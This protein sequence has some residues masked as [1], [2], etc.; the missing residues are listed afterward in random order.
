[1]ISYKTHPFLLLRKM[2]KS[3]AILLIVL[4]LTAQSTFSQ[5]ADKDKITL[6]FESSVYYGSQKNDLSVHL[7][8][9][10]TGKADFSA[11]KSA[12]WEDI[13]SLFDYA[14]SKA[15]IPS[16]IKDISKYIQKG[17]P[18]FI[19]FKYMGDASA[20]STQR[21]WIIRNL[22]A[23]RAGTNL[24]TS[25]LIFVNNPENDEN[26]GWEMFGK[27]FRYR[28]R[29]TKKASESW[30]IVEVFPDKKTAEAKKANISGKTTGA[31]T[32]KAA[33]NQVSQDEIRTAM[34]NL[35]LGKGPDFTKYA[36][37][38]M[39]VI[40]KFKEVGYER[41]HI[42]YLVDENEYAHAYLLI[43]SG[44]VKG[45]KLPAVICP[46][47]TADIGKDR[48]VGIYAEPAK[49]EKDQISRENRRY[50]TDLVEKGFVVI[51][52]DRAAYG[53]RRLENGTYKT[54][55]P[56]FQKYLNAKHPGFSLV[57]KSVYD[58]RIALNV[59]ISLDFVDSENIGVIGHSLGAWDAIMLVA[60]EPRVK[61]A[62]VNSG[63]MLTFDQKLWDPNSG[64]LREYLK[65]P[66]KSN[67][68]KNTNLFIM[69]AAPRAI[70]YQY[71]LF[72]SFNKGNPNILEAHR[73]ITEYYQ[74]ILKKKWVDFNFYMHNA[75]H[76]F[77]RESRMLSY[78]WLEAR[79]KKRSDI[80][81]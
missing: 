52:P 26:V 27:A 42:K 14:D 3:S 45:K 18:L 19:A 56:A 60:F 13:T 31:A 47:P 11:V 78:A 21:M 66:Q 68:G 75:G 30:A 34:E 57:G 2:Y 8:T 59:L 10:Y 23:Q 41:W 81:N 73:S 61:A 15:Y 62:V 37:P 58:L 54:E 20:N 4:L 53:E 1:M 67:L 43:P 16:G 38:K 28:S 64:D 24:E 74:S 51:A 72:D 35:Y 77:T 32:E 50:A 39:E 12:K 7:S 36:H 46:H 48:V 33:S 70:L 80:I 22:I 63:G 6:S 9:D 29:L 76:D 71:S 65:N 69:M 25:D 55:M 17:K 44:I 40:N 5:F 49:N 79:L